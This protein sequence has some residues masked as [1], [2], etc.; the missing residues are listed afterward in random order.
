[1]PDGLKSIIEV[2]V[3]RTLR[4]T[5]ILCWTHDLTKCISMGALKCF[6]I[7]LRRDDVL[8]EQ[9][10]VRVKYNNYR[11][12][13]SD[14]RFNRLLYNLEVLG[15]LPDTPDKVTATLLIRFYEMSA[16]K[17]LE[18][19][20]I[21]ERV[22][23]VPK[24]EIE[25]PAVYLDLGRYKVGDAELYVGIRTNLAQGYI[26]PSYREGKKKYLEYKE[27]LKKVDDMDLGKFFEVE[28]GAY[29]VEG[30]VVHQEVE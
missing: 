25:L 17:E 10:E 20:D 23:W 14:F 5:L 1:M 12:E 4:D 16:Q 2:E 8:V 26:Y 3:V 7:E 24:G 30:D 6:F 22:V 19:Q 21:K 13:L 11:E 29:L 15:Q 9:L 28:D 27:A 18:I